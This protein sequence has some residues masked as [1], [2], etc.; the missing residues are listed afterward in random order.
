MHWKGGV[1]VLKHCPLRGKE[2]DVGRSRRWSRSWNRSRFFQAGVG[3]GVEVAEIWSTPQH[4][5]RG[6]HLNQLW[7]KWRLAW[8]DSDSTHIPDF[9]GL[10]NF[11]PTHLS[12]SWIKVD[13]RLSESRTTLILTHLF[14]SVWLRVPAPRAS[15]FSP[16]MMPNCINLLCVSVWWWRPQQWSRWSMDSLAPINRIAHLQIALEIYVDWLV[17]MYVL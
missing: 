8:F 17:C 2:T 9:H 13:S 16:N 3:V 12:Q 1:T 5:S 15:D 4:C 7:L 11:D 14:L 10:L 6:I